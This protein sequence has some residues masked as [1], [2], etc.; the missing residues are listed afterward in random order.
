MP[1]EPRVITQRPAAR[2]T[3]GPPQWAGRAHLRNEDEMFEILRPRRA[4]PA[5]GQNYFTA[6]HFCFWLDSN[7]FSN[8]FMPQ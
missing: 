8:T 2:F 6:I 5:G 3:P 4:E 7:T 1:F